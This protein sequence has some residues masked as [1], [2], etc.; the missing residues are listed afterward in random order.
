MGEYERG[1]GEIK[2]L[3]CWRAAPFWPD[4]TAAGD[5]LVR[6]CLAML[7]AWRS[8]RILADGHLPAPGVY[9]I[10]DAWPHVADILTRAGFVHIGRV[11]L[12]LAAEVDA[13]A[14]PGEAPI[15]GLTL[16]REL[17]INGT[18]FAKRSSMVTEIAMIEIESDLTHGGARVRL[19]GWADIGNLQVDEQ[20]R[21][22]RCRAMA[23]RSC[24][25]LAPA[26]PRPRAARVCG[27]RRGC[28]A[29]PS[30]RPR[31]SA[32]SAERDAAGSTGRSSTCPDTSGMDER[33]L[34]VAAAAREAG[35]GWAIVTSPDPVC[36]A[37][38]FESPYETGPSPFGGGPAT[39]LIAPDG[40]AH[41][42]V[43]NAELGGA[44]ASRAATSTGYE[45]FSTERRCTAGRSTPRRSRASPPTSG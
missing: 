14:A 9:G 42:I 18:R 4:A 26:R 38:G 17:G 39:A 7:A 33:Q 44:E 32:N 37:T 40:T 35:A 25:G 16:R 13:I 6:G 15:A 19:A 28:R 27:S 1:A 21:R 41:L 11:E 31:G 23:A 3:L 8:E 45:G 24:R 22:Q 12:V 20:H 10:P 36:Y 5:A 30:C 34:R 29:A 2:W 43:V